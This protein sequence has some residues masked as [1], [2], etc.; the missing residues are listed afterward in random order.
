MACLTVFQA[1]GLAQADKKLLSTVARL[2]WAIIWLD[3]NTVV[4]PSLF[5]VLLQLCVNSSQLTTLYTLDLCQL[6]LAAPPSTL[7]C[8]ASHHTHNIRR[9]AAK[10]REEENFWFLFDQGE[11][12]F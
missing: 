7:Y 3:N 1:P 4:S 10:T 5:T 8:P 9:S 6:L 11:A 12:E 2:Y